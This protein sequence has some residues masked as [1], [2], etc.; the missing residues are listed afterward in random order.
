MFSVVESR[1]NWFIVVVML[2]FSMLLFLRLFRV[3][4][5]RLRLIFRLFCRVL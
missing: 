4:V 5:F 2:K 1:W 3:R